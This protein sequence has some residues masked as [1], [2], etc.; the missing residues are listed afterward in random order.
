VEV[1][2]KVLLGRKKCLAI[3]RLIDPVSPATAQA[4]LSYSR[5][6]DLF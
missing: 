2:S 5:V 6:P 3:G 4:L 1:I